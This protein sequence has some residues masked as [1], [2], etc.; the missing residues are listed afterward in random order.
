M[1]GISSRAINV[2]ENRR[3]WNKG[4]ELQSKEFSD[5]S[6]LD[7]YS[8]FY[9][10][11]DPQLGRFWQ[12]DPRPNQSISL[13]ASMENNPIG[14]N[15]PLGDTLLNKQDERTASSIQNGE[16][17]NIK[18]IDKIL[19]KIES[20]INSGD[21]SQSLLNRQKRLVM[22]RAASSANIDKIDDLRSS[23]NRYTFNT[24]GKDVIPELQT[25]QTRTDD[26]GNIYN[27]VTVINNDGSLP[28]RLH[29]LTHAHHHSK[30]LLL[31][32]SHLQSEQGAYLA[33]YFNSA[34][35][36]PESIFFA[37]GINS[38]SD[39]ISNPL[40][41]SGIYQVTIFGIRIAPR[42]PLPRLANMTPIY[43]DLWQQNINP[44]FI[45]LFNML[46]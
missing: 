35:S 20:R 23:E 18:R 8:T 22:Q 27:N 33:Q 28:N 5:G 17:R 6:G 19:A 10:S 24:V 11:L 38:P 14:Y 37:N 2:L 4:S 15:D 31:T 16:R 44:I 34:A 9:R 45:Q 36:M 32:L 29:E 42:N 1:A 39:I 13:Y 46:L 40:Y 3:K 41:V 43:D 26:N 7:L 25:G 21:Q 30:G 12:I